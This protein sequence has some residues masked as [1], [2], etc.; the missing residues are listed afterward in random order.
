MS[1]FSQK[2]YLIPVIYLSAVF[3]CSL[4]LFFDVKGSFGMIST[5]TLFVLTIPWSLLAGYFIFGALHLGDESPV[6]VIFFV[7][8]YINACLLY[9]KLAKKGW[10]D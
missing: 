9:K 1:K 3:V 10:M 4:I 2:K 7:F 5:M 8:G 6:A